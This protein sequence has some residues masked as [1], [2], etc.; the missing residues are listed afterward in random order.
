MSC[1]EWTGVRLS[2]VLDEAGLDARA[3]WMLAEGA[4]AAGM[5]RSIPIAKALDDALL[6]YA[7]NGERLR[8]EQGYPLRL[9]PSG[10]RGQ[11]QRQMAAPPQTRRPTVS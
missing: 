6:V 11:H 7:Q 4:D 5:A 9:L 2:T 3:T 1:C 10:L 8:P